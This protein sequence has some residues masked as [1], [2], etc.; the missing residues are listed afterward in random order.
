M[1]AANSGHPPLE[2]VLS[3]HACR[4]AKDLNVALSRRTRIDQVCMSRA[5]ARRVG[6][7]S[8]WIRVGLSK[9]IRATNAAKD[10]QHACARDHR[11]SLRSP[12]L[13]TGTIVHKSRL[14]VPIGEDGPAFLQQIYR[15]ET[16][17]PVDLGL[18]QNGVPQISLRRRIN[19]RR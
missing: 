19:R 16:S 13:H 15:A 5:G 17:S 18:G 14:L 4:L 9:R 12:R 6:D 2:A 1:S 11:P 8:R 3:R 10:R 7:T